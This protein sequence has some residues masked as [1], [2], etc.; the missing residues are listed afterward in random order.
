MMAQKT[1]IIAV[2]LVC[3]ILQPML[4]LGS[5]TPSAAFRANM[6]QRERSPNTLFY[7][8]GASKQYGD[9]IKD[10]IYKRFKPCYYSPIQCLIKRK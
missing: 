1:L 5:L 7:M 3:S 9:E 4:A 8:D 2:M 10:P 6:Q